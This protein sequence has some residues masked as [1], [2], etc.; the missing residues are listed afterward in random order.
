M[1]TP[2]TQYKYT[3][4]VTKRLLDS[5]DY[6]SIPGLELG[7]DINH[8]SHVKLPKTRYRWG[9][10]ERAARIR[11]MQ[12]N[13]LRRPLISSFD[14][15][16]F[17]TKKPIQQSRETIFSLWRRCKPEGVFGTNFKHKL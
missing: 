3:P 14:S 10:F 7:D 15:E 6:E 2:I 9:F 11:V 4:I 13:D 8:T 5:F 17:G 16:K 12:G 1:F